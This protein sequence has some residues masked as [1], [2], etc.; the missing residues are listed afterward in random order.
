LLPFLVT[1]IVLLVGGI[2]SIILLPREGGG[3]ANV[4]E[5][6]STRTSGQKLVL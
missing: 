4:A 3:F 6:T 1:G 5:T 2:V